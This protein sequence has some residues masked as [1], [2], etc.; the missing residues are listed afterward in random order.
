ML[1]KLP[2]GYGE[3]QGRISRKGQN[4]KGHRV[5]FPQDPAQGFR[6]SVSKRSESSLG[7]TESW[8][9]GAKQNI[10]QGFG[11]GS[12][13]VNGIETEGLQ[14]GHQKGPLTC[15]RFS[16]KRGSKSCFVTIGLKLKYLQDD[17]H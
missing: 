16:S 8:R 17:D 3:W 9:L 4:T 1:M 14:T 2:K 12:R 5:W 11:F 10:A 13:N 6:F 15:R 7:L